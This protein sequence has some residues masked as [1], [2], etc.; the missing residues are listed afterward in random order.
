MRHDIQLHIFTNAVDLA[1][2]LTL[3][4]R[5]YD[6][7]CKMFGGDFHV[8]VWCDPHPNIEKADAYIDNL[9]QTF[10]RVHVTQSLS[11]GYVKAVL[12]ST[13]DYLFMLEHD[14]L[15]LPTIQHSLESIVRVM[16]EDDILHLRFNKR[17]NFAKKSD[18]DLAPVNHPTVPYCTTGFLSNNPHLIARERY[19]KEALPLI[20]VREKSFGIEKNLSLSSLTGAIYGPLG[21]PATVQHLD[22]KHFSIGLVQGPDK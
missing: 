4:T 6:S 12:G 5:T 17:S 16:Q 11:D 19:L 14:W 10:D 1:P 18:I 2:D 15:F 20:T 22:G 21:H 13:A 9:K 8:D 3:I 7:F